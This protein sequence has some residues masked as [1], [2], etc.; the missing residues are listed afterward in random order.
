MY[1]YGLLPTDHLGNDI[2]PQGLQTI[3]NIDIL[4]IIFGTIKIGK[5]R[6]LCH[7]I[8]KI[9]QRSEIIQFARL[10]VIIIEVPQGMNGWIESAFHQYATT[11]H[12]LDPNRSNAFGEYHIFPFDRIENNMIQ[13]SMRLNDPNQDFGGLLHQHGLV[14]LM[15]EWLLLLWRIKNPTQIGALYTMSYGVLDL[16][17]PNERNML[18]ATAP[19]LFSSLAFVKAGITETNNYMTF[20]ISTN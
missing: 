5:A 14:P 16:L 9:L 6:H 11:V 12:S 10:K 17:T 20:F 2:S 1:A 7:A 15:Q 3:N 19:A 18:Q 13:L 4:R 8:R